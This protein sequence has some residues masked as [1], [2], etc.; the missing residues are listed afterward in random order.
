VVKAVVAAAKANG[1]D[2][3]WLDRSAD[4]TKGLAENA[5]RFFLEIAGDR[6][7][8]AAVARRAA[9]GARPSRTGSVPRG[10][11]VR[12]RLAGTGPGRGRW[13]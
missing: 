4:A 3:R 8:T 6:P 11:P 1:R 2:D 12:S 9:D 13:P 7:E 10:W 5:V